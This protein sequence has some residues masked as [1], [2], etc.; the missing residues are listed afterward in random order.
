MGVAWCANDNQSIDRHACTTPDRLTSSSLQADNSIPLGMGVVGTALNGVA[1]NEM[2]DQ[3]R[4]IVP[5]AAHV[6]GNDWSVAWRGRGRR[7]GGG[8][9]G[10]AP[11]RHNVDAVDP[12]SSAYFRGVAAAGVVA[13][14]GRGSDGLRELDIVRGPAIC[15]T[16]G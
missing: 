8:D 2:R 1:S 14:I 11:S 3:A 13:A 16:R 10:R 12:P 7:R 5:E 9:I 4:G 6:L 15:A